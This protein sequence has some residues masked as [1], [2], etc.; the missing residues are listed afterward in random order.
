[1]KGWIIIPK[2]LDLLGK[3]FTR[4]TVIKELPNRD[5]FGNVIW[6]CLCDCGNIG[7][8]SSSLLNEGNSKSCGCL[9]ID[10]VQ[11]KNGISKNILYDRYKHILDRC[12]NE[13][14]QAYKDY[15]GRGIKVQREWFDNFNLFYEYISNLPNFNKIKHLEIDRIDNDKGYIYGNIKLS[16][17]SENCGNRRTNKIIEV[18]DPNGNRYILKNQ[19][20]F[21][22]QHAI[23]PKTFCGWLNGRK[24]KDGW[25]VKYLYE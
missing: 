16:T 1:M 23:N 12:Y 6:E 14:C 20:I 7:Y 4:W 13:N 11:T 15:G 8:V 2:K 9:Q 22:K 24:S 10:T 17:K 25:S 21:C 19:K 5:K 18:I 3:K